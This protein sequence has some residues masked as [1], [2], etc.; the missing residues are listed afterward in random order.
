M[1]IIR[2]KW[3]HA[4]HWKQGFV[5]AETLTSSL[6]GTMLFF[7]MLT[8]LSNGE[9]LSPAARCTRLLIDIKTIYN[10]V[11]ESG[12]VWAKALFP[13][14]KADV[15]DRAKWFLSA[16]SY[17]NWHCLLLPGWY[18]NQWPLPMNVMSAPYENI[19]LLWQFLVESA[20]AKLLELYSSSWVRIF[21]G[22][23]P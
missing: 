19:V 12:Y 5:R 3:P 10:L 1:G 8:T 2:K 16:K 13:V 7:F 11:T 9:E 22:R 20:P 4:R 23:V 14:R 18:R 6:I 21:R 15:W 17:S